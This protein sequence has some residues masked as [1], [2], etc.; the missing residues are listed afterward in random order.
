MG[1]VLH[2]YSRGTAFNLIVDVVLID[3]G[4]R[5]LSLPLVSYNFVKLHSLGLFL[6]S[7]T[8]KSVA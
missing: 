5:H 6:N 3:F 4:V 8:L 1:I 7:I 2:Y